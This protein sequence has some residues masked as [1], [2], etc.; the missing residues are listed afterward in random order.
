M[1]AL[2]ETKDLFLRYKRTEPVFLVAARGIT[3]LILLAVLGG[4]FAILTIFLA[5]DGG[6]IKSS[7]QPASTI[8]IPD[9][10]LVFNYHFNISCV[11]RYSDGSESTAEECS[12]YILQPSCNNF[13]SDDRWHGYF[14][15]IDGLVFNQTAKRY[16]MYFTINIDDPRYVRDNDKG[17]M[18]K[19]FD[20]EFNP[21]TVPLSVNKSAN[22]M[23]GE[24]FQS[25]DDLNL[26]VIGFQ[27]MNWM[28]INRHIRK[29]EISNFWSLLG[30][31]PQHF[32][33]PYITTKYEA[34]TNPGTAAFAN[35]PI[36]GQ[37]LYANLFVGTMNWFQT[38][39]TEGKSLRIMDSLGLLAGFYGL[40][41][42]IYI[43]LFG[44][45][46]VHPWGLCQSFFLRRRLKKELRKQYPKS[47]PLLERPSIDETLNERINYLEQFVKQFFCDVGFMED[48]K[49]ENELDDLVDS[50]VDNAETIGKFAK[51]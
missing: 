44:F 42:G 49:H 13:T 14:T 12:P 25:L 46:P 31:P 15:A 17:M 43:L 45:P 23:D 18:I 41:I 22:E 39:E 3:I 50:A 10:E 28:F 36:T 11:F 34:V 16:A 38:I 9:L 51:R 48:W 5:T 19:A 33:E 7:L 6:V 47:I 1:E 30:I 8:P 27:Q 2:Y 37:Q 40:L 32:E 35:Q 24:F 4:Y 29:K 26:H 21:I 20:S